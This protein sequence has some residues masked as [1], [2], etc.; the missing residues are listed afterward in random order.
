MS[1]EVAGNHR[2]D[3]EVRFARVNDVSGSQLWR[4]FVE[5]FVIGTSNKTE[6]QAAVCQMKMH[7]LCKSLPTLA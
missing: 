4:A 7:L 6:P 2:Q 3:F 5:A 1:L